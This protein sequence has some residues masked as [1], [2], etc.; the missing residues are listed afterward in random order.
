MEPFNLDYLLYVRHMGRFYRVES[1]ARDIGLDS[2]RDL[3]YDEGCQ[4]NEFQRALQAD[5]L[6][7]CLRHVFD[8]EI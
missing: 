1:A 3:G 8:F 7:N 4:R 6:A 5:A 2:T